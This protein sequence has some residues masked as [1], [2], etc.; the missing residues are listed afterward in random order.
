MRKN[1]EAG[2]RAARLR[3]SKYNVHEKKKLKKKI[4]IIHVARLHSRD[5]RV[6][7]NNRYG[8]SGT[9][10]GRPTTTEP[11][12]RPPSSSSATTAAS[13]AAGGVSALPDEVFR[14]REDVN[15]S[16][17]NMGDSYISLVAC[18]DERTRG[19]NSR[20]Y[21]PVRVSPFRRVICTCEKGSTLPRKQISF[22]I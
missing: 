6:N 19:H 2:S 18:R 7:A 14:L 15:W 22:V 5:I 8:S 21:S 3:S 12:T 16:N 10:L 17:R 11:T 13:T 1:H 4:K 20:C 9:A